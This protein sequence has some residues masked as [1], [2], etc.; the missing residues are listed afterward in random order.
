M[1]DIMLVCCAGVSM[2][3]L[4]V[5]M[6]KA[7]EERGLKVN[8]FS[9]SETEANKHFDNISVLLLG[10]QVRYLKKKLVAQLE[11]LGVPVEVINSMQYGTLNGKAVLD[12]ALALAE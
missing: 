5:K 10:P 12:A 7:A 4:A 11:P 2:S 3:L 8:I 1:K 6:E 9:V